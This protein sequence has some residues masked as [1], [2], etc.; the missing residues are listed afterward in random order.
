M[1]GLIN[2]G[3]EDLV[4]DNFGKEKWLLIQKEAGLEDLE[5]VSM[6]SYSDDLTYRLIAAASRVLSLKEEEI[7]ETFGEYWITFTARE[8]YGNLLDMAG[9]SLH[10]F[11]NNLDQLHS[12]VGHLLPKLTPPSFKCTD[13]T[14][15]SLRLHHYTSRSNL[16]H[17]VTGLIKGLG[18]KFNL[19]CSVQLEQSKDNGADHNVFYIQWS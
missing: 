16:H 1:Y 14:P 12:V 3:I 18:K 15:N 5:F 8:G 19:N 4:I 9:N 11:L 17:M 7:L 6:Q 13:V 2:K 10:D